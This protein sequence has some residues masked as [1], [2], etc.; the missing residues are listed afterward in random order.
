M[1]VKLTNF[2]IERYINIISSP[3]SFRN[4][5]GVKISAEMDW[6][7]RINIK[8]MTDR[9]ALFNEAR[10]ELA[11]EFIDSGKVDGD[12]IK[13]EYIPEYNQRITVLYSQKN[14][15]D[16]ATI[17]SEDIKHLSNLSMPER[18]FLNLM[19]EKEPETE[20]A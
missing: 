1:K 15:L 17:K 14:E 5:V 13:E 2:E 10:E 8:T 6:A 4:N 19:V 11:Q 3:E 18:D 20:E 12:M 7:L 16:L 9:F